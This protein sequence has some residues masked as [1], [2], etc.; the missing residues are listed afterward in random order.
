MIPHPM[1]NISSPYQRD[2]L[3]MPAAT[4]GRV[5]PAHHSTDSIQILLSIN[6]CT[7][8]ALSLWFHVIL[9]L[10]HEENDSVFLQ[11]FWFFFLFSF[12]LPFFLWAKDGIGANIHFH[13]SSSL[14]T[15]RAVNRGQHCS[16]MQS[17]CLRF[18]ITNFFYRQEYIFFLETFKD[19]PNSAPPYS[20]LP[21]TPKSFLF[22]GF[23]ANWC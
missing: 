16:G 20:S 8:A 23:I 9:L 15:I 21:S 18:K 4:P 11:Q 3:G 7:L 10:S 13:G 5:S 19:R 1:A 2:G 17:I 6:C 12:F 14:R 22:I